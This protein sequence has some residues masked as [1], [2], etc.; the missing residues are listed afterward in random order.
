[1]DGNY[2]MILFYLILYI[3]SFIIIIITIQ[4]I[5]FTEV[6]PTE[7]LEHKQNNLAPTGNYSK[8]IRRQSE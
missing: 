6:G 3:C 5:V 7:H 1:M 2:K 8:Q 4:T